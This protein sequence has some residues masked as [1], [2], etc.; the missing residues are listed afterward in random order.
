MDGMLIGL[1]AGSRTP[2]LRKSLLQIASG[3]LTSLHGST[4]AI[5][6]ANE[7]YSF[8]LSSSIPTWRI[9]STTFFHHTGSALLR[10]RK[11]YI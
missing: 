8:S 4:Y 6:Y 2:S 5:G 9:K 10:P 7:I 3:M 1:H 11:E